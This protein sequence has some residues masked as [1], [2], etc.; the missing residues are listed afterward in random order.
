MRKYVVILLVSLLAGCASM[1]SQELQSARSAVAQA[2]AVDAPRF[3]PQEYESAKA[4]LSDAER[5]V[6]YGEYDE[7]RSILPLAEG[8]ALR[9]YTKARE[10]AA[11]Q[12][13][14]AEAATSVA[15]GSSNRGAAKPVKKKSLTPP[16]PKANSDAK[17]EE[18]APKTPPKVE[19]LVS[20]YTVVDGE[21]LWTI[22]A[23]GEVYGDAL[24]WPLIYKANRDQIKD[25]RQIFPGQVLSIPRDVPPEEMDEAREKAR[26]SD[27]FPLDVMLRMGAPAKE[28]ERP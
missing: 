18:V 6:H 17:K 20:K 25:P 10:E 15:S 9:A 12:Q 26:Q 8:H 4:A 27:I 28:P 16:S 24:L 5:Y 7:A 19:P 11:R 21:T 14:E 2:Y 3:A 13:R 1:P 23:R 22:S